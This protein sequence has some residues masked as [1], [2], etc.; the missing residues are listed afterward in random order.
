MRIKPV[1]K[2]FTWSPKTIK[3][4]LH[5]YIHVYNFPMLPALGESDSLSERE[6]H[7]LN[8]L[9]DVLS[10]MQINDAYSKNVKNRLIGAHKRLSIEINCKVTDTDWIAWERPD[11]S[12]RMSSA[13]LVKVFQ[14]AFKEE[15]KHFVDGKL[16]YAVEP[17]EEST[18]TLFIRN[19][20]SPHPDQ[21]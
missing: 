7:Y 21:G 13:L 9:V 6:P 16:I 8:Y 3:T 5:S 11:L 1:P 12:E 19:Y 20:G 18:C 15:G 10:W 2:V 4:S 17:V 14:Q